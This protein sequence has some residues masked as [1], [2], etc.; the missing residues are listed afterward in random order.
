MYSASSKPSTGIRYLHWLNGFTTFSFAV[1]FSS[2]TL[3]L[4]NGLNLSNEHSNNIVGLFLAL[5]FALHLLAGY[6]GGRF[7]SNRLLYLI[8]LSFQ[9]IG[10]HLLS[11]LNSQYL[12]WGLCFF[13]MGCG[14]NSTCLNCMLTQQFEPDDNKR[15]AAFFINYCAMN[16][17]FFIGFLASG[18]FDL[19]QN[20]QNLFY[21]CNI[22][23][24]LTLLLSIYAWNYLGDKNTPLA[25]ISKTRHSG[26]SKYQV[27]G[28]TIILLLIPIIFL[29]FQRANLANNLVLI[30]GSCV[31]GFI[32]YFAVRNKNILEK[33]KVYAYLILTSASIVFWMLYFVGPMGIMHFL[34]YNAYLNL[35]TYKIPPQWVL[36]L[37]TLFVITGSPLIALILSKLRKRGHNIQ[38]SAQFVIALTTIALSFYLLSIGIYFAD[39]AGMSSSIWII[40]HFLTQAIGELLL[41]PVGF[42]MIGKLA[43]ANLQ[44][45]MMGTWMMVSGIAATLAHYFSNE[46]T[47]TEAIDPLITNSQYL[48]TFNQLGLYALIGALILYM[49]SSRLN[50]YINQ[51]SESSNEGLLAEG[52]L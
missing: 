10:L 13:L 39:P 12:F 36:N 5:N 46:M 22:I 47:L 50:G 15:E 34:K 16:A 43:P 7:L 30:L 20:Y 2:L 14:F 25:N 48:H 32:L 21:L 44:G 26:Q 19:L 28:V 35:F 40:M 45:I 3:Y 27:I 9:I 4:T 29:G 42:A 17:G 23:N 52:A 8:S 33:N 6:I 1:L 11:M 18:I 24:I 51:T 38:I 37:N 49:L 31:L 41:A